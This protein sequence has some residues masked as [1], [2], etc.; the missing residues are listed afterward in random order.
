LPFPT[1]PGWAFRFVVDGEFVST[2]EG[3]PPLIRLGE[4]LDATRRLEQNRELPDDLTLIFAPG[5]SLGGARPKASILDNNGQ[6]SIAKFPKDG[7]TYSVERWEYIALLVAR[8]AG[9]EVADAQLIES[10]GGPVLLSR[11]FDRKGQERVHFC[12]AM[13]LLGLRDGDHASYPDIADLIQTE[14]SRPAADSEELFRRMVL[15]ICIANVDD[16]L[17]NHGFLRSESGWK[18]SPAYDLNPVPAEVRPRILS[19]NVSVDDAT[20]SLSLAR[21]AA[22]LRLRGSSSSVAQHDPS[23]LFGQPARGT[24]AAW[25]TFALE[26][27]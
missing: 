27:S 7:D 17:R 1:S 15:S 6:L 23:W 16:H 25:N 20:G 18:L 22:P 2:S 26:A 5:S 3:V 9:I 14:G 10:A 21:E 4:L 19:T 11:R 24:A 8:A 12:S 13:T